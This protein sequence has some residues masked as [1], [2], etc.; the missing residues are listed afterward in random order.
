MA[1][2]KTIEFMINKV[3]ALTREAAEAKEK[4]RTLEAESDAQQK[5]IAELEA[6]VAELEKILHDMKHTDIH[7]ENNNGI[8]G[9]DISNSQVTTSD[10]EQTADDGKEVPGD[11]G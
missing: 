6:R 7:I 11:E 3:E 1:D 9:E 8:V 4:L 10:D 5:R 2:F